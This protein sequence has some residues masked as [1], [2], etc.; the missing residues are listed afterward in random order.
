MKLREVSRLFH[1]GR[2]DRA[3]SCL[4]SYESEVKTMH[5]LRFRVQRFRGS[6][7]QG[8]RGLEFADDKDSESV[9]DHTFSMTGSSL[10]ALRS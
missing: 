2:A 1:F 8:F 4:A 5:R 10:G 3:C 6:D 9:S 7:V